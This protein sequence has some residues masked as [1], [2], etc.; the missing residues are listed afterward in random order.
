[1]KK[2]F[3][4]LIFLA[5][6]LFLFVYTN[7]AIAQNV[8]INGGMEIWESGSP[9]GW[10]WQSSG[11][12]A[13]PEDSI[14]HGGSMSAAMHVTGT[15]PW[16]TDFGQTLQYFVEEGEE[17]EFSAWVYNTE[18]HHFMAMAL[19][20]DSNYVYTSQKGYAPARTDYE[21]VGEWQQLYLRWV[22]EWS[23]TVDISF[24]FWNVES[25]PDGEVIYVDDVSF[26]VYGSESFNSTDLIWADMHDANTGWVSNM[27]SSYS[28]F[29][30]PVIKDPQDYNFDNLNIWIEIEAAG[31]GSGCSDDINQATNTRVEFGWT[32][33]YV[34]WESTNEW[35]KFTESKTQIGAAHGPNVAFPRPCGKEYAE[36]YTM[37][38]IEDS[39]DFR[40]V[41]I[42]GY[43]RWHG[44]APQQTLPDPDDIKAIYGE[45]S[46]RLIKDD[47][48]GSDDRHLANFVTHISSDRRLDGVY[49]G[50]MGISRYK[51]VTNEWQPINFL[52]GGITR[53]E[54]ETN[55]PPFDD[56]TKSASLLTSYRDLDKNASPFLRIRNLG[57]EV[58]IDFSLPAGGRK[59]T[60]DIYA[61]D[62]R[63]VWSHQARGAGKH[64]VRWVLDNTVVNGV[65]IVRLRSSDKTHSEKLAIN[66]L[67]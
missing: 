16:Q 6:A 62:G 51:K 67:D 10:D 53:A 21:I 31:D 3:T 14:V 33:G 11:I 37:S 26:M 8:L 2:N 65:Y 32:R 46:V 35:E 48:N 55:P 19:H 44:W 43:W 66:R 40:S 36:E 7:K 22:A 41:Y 1:M 27:P 50:D 34:L 45:C 29:Q 17:Y 5:T 13:T 61:I 20:G 24:R 15:I 28:Q 64:T 49:K 42:E 58:D 18:G 57:S 59:F 52:S 38:R 23:D 63:K 25:D 9:T 30:G 56:E 12:S 39:T 47:P 60:L 54:L 4:S